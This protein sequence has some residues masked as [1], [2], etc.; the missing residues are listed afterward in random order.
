[1]PAGGGGFKSPLRHSNRCSL[2]TRVV[3]GWTWCIGVCWRDHGYAAGVEPETADDEW[4]VIDMAGWVPGLG[5]DLVGFRRVGAGGLDRRVIPHGRVTV[6]FELSGALVELGQGG[7]GQA[8]HFSAHFVCGL[9]AAPLRVRADTVD[10]VEIQM[11]PVAAFSCL[12]VDL[13][14]I[15]GEPCDVEELWGAAGRELQERLLGTS[16][17]Q[18]RAAL[19]GSALMRRR[20]LQRRVDPEVAEAWDSIVASRGTVQVNWLAQQSGWNRKRLWSR[21]STQIGLSPKRAARLV[22]FEHATDRL[23]AGDSPADV[24]AVCGY[25]DQSHLHRDVL[26]FAECTPSQ[27]T[28]EMGSVDIGS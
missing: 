10:C 6:V 21:F 5:V 12:G 28:A 17:W 2:S 16:E 22:R 13:A 20:A 23:A 11:S 8:N 27:L 26:S 4:D 1:M 9:G 7:T 18:E 14:S 19:V 25:F 15:A 3:A 24:A